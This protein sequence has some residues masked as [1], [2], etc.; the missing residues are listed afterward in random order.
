MVDGIR[1]MTL[2]LYFVFFI[3]HTKEALCGTVLVLSPV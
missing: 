2:K 3:H 1:C